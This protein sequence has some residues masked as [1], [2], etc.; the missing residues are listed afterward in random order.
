MLI[1][2]F[3]FLNKTLKEFV[4]SWYSNLSADESFVL[5][6]RQSIRYAASVLLRRGLQVSLIMYRYT[7]MHLFVCIVRILLLNFFTCYYINWCILIFLGYMQGSA[8]IR[9]TSYFLYVYFFSFPV[10]KQVS[11]SS[12]CHLYHSNHSAVF[13]CSICHEAV[14][15]VVSFLLVNVLS[16]WKLSGKMVQPLFWGSGTRILTLSHLLIYHLWEKFGEHGTVL[17]AIR[18]GRL[19]S[20]RTKENI[21]AVVHSPEE[22]MLKAPLIRHFNLFLMFRSWPAWRWLWWMS[23]VSVIA[24]KQF[25]EKPQIFR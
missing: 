2:I 22:S 8:K 5:E 25:Q 10:H 24:M 1:V 14:C 20:V 18:N 13:L 3:Q 15:L 12:C 21:R 19:R 4:Y 11:A 17:D 9:H 6:L 7:K 16:C 23:P